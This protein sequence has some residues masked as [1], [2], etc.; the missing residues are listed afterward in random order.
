MA[1]AYMGKLTGGGPADWREKKALMETGWRPYSIVYTDSTTGLKTYIPFSRFDPIAQMLGVA[2]D[3]VEL[4]NVRDPKDIV[5]KA[6]GSIG[7][8]FTNRTYLKGLMDWS[9]A[10]SDP[11]NAGARYMISIGTM[12]IPRMAGRLASAIDPVMRDVRPT[13]R[14]I[15]GFGERVVKSAARNIPGLSTKVPPRYGPTGEPI[16]RPGT[17]LGGAAMRLLSPIQISKERTGR[18]LEGLM[19][20]IGAVPG[21]PRNFMTIRGEQIMLDREHIDILHL[22]DRNAANEL[23]RLMR[24]PMWELLPD[25]LEEG[26]VNSKKGQIRKSYDKYRDLAKQMILRSYTFRRSAMQQLTESARAR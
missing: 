22:A 3:L 4:P 18:E 12:H 25:S 2:S 14:G 11:A 20:E 19:A 5:S 26:G 7:E 13:S 6:I 17:G 21:E 9:D 8:N 16:V 15:G 24:N 23:R 1:A 10:M